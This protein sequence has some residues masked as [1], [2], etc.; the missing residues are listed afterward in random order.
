MDFPIAI[1][2]S[3]SN[4]KSWSCRLQSTAAA[5]EES[6][7]YI[8]TLQYTRLCNWVM[9]ASSDRSLPLPCSPTPAGNESM[10]RVSLNCRPHRVS[11]IFQNVRIKKKCFCFQQYQNLF[12]WKVS[13]WFSF[14]KDRQGWRAGRSGFL[15][16][17]LCQ[18][19]AVLWVV[20]RS[21]CGM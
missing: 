13:S 1:N 16:S 6:L 11:A 14:N 4:S 12:S 5:V 3:F 8:L 2:V 10:C 15:W 18:T 9:P 7:H 17:Q 20:P 19:N 21:D